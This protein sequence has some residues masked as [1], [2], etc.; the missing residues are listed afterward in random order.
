MI[1]F[2]VYFLVHEVMLRIVDSHMSYCMIMSDSRSV[3]HCMHDILHG[4][5]VRMYIIMM[6]RI[7]R[8]C[9]R[10]ALAGHQSLY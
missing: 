5:K 4:I 6:H 2:L 3:N 7:I 8:N 10:Q 9:Y 1:L